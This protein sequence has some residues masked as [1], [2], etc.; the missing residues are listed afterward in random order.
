[1]RGCAI[2]AAQPHS[3]IADTVCF[4]LN[5]RYAFK[6]EHLEVLIVHS[7]LVESDRTVVVV[8]VVA[9]SGRI[10][11]ACHRQAVAAVSGLY[12]CKLEH[13]VESRDAVLNCLCP[14]G[15]DGAGCFRKVADV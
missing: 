1:M 7:C 6:T 9:A 8:E 12:A 5:V 11:A 15:G 3:F 4:C 10:E 2:I 13:G 14:V